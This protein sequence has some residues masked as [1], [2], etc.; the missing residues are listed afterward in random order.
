METHTIYVELLGEGVAAWRP[1]EAVAERT[2]TF[3][4][5][6]TAP[7]DE[8]WRFAPGTLVRGEE[9]ILAEGPV[10]VAVGLPD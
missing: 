4:L 3:R 1:V 9:R 7:S 8:S 2:D 6:D 5:P 10:L